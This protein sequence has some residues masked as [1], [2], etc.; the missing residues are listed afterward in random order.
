MFYIVSDVKGKVMCFHPIPFIWQNRSQQ[1]WP[2]HRRGRQ[3]KGLLHHHSQQPTSHTYLHHRSGIKQDFFMQQT[4]QAEFCA[5]GW[6]ECF[7]WPKRGPHCACRCHQASLHSVCTVTII[8]HCMC[9]PCDTAVPGDV[10]LL[11]LP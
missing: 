8:S 2:T 11:H 10:N 1:T 4:E 5:R 3:I 7:I 9:W 6:H